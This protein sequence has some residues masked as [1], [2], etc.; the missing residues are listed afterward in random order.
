MAFIPQSMTT[1]PGFTQSPFTN[2][3]CPIPTTKISALRHWNRQNL[4]K[5]DNEN[6]LNY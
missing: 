3:G 2:S 1:A 6:H 5:Q 4:H